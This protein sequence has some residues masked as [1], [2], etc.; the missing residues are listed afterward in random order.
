M[1]SQGDLCL[2]SEQMVDEPCQSPNVGSCHVPCWVMAW[3]I[4]P[5]EGWP[6]CRGEGWTW[7]RLGADLR[8]TWNL[9]R[10]NTKVADRH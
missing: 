3:T 9:I 6:I 10:S 7:D 2:S 5:G 4:C 1:T 8:L